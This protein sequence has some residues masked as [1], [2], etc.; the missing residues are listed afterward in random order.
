M[1]NFSELWKVLRDLWRAG[2][3]GVVLFLV[4][5]FVVIY[6]YIALDYEVTRGWNGHASVQNVLKDLSTF[7]PVGVAIVGMIIGGIDLMMLLSD[8]FLARQEKRIQAARE[9]GR[10]EGRE[11]VREEAYSEGREKGYAEGYAAAKAENG[12]P[13]EESPDSPSKPSPRTSEK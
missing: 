1:E 13:V 4:S 8:W 2:K 9:E 5:L 6:G 7:I 11:E 3:A 12:V 10:E